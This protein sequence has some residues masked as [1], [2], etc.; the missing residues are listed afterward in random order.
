MY[1]EEIEK[2]IERETQLMQTMDANSDEYQKKLNTI[3][4]LSGVAER[5]NKNKEVKK[6]LDEEKFEL[7]KLQAKHNK[8]LEEDKFEFQKAQAD[9]SNELAREKINN[10]LRRDVVQNEKESKE[11][12]LRLVLGVLGIVIPSGIQ[13]V[14]LIFYNRLAVRTLNMEYIDNGVSPRLFGE[15][16]KNVNQFI[17]K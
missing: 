15:S 2:E 1:L 4:K 7:Q 10:D 3:I 6:N 14:S 16:M 5:M 11:R 12:K 9:I 8:K 13:L 17:K